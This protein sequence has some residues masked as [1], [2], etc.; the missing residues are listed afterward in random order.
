MPDVKCAESFTRQQ[1]RT[2]GWSGS[3]FR[4]GGGRTGVCRVGGGQISNPG[5]FVPDPGVWIK[6]GR[7]K[8]FGLGVW[9]G[10]ANPSFSRPRQPQTLQDSPRVRMVHSERGGD[11]QESRGGV[12]AGMATPRRAP[13]RAPLPGRPRRQQGCRKSAGHGR[14]QCGREAWVDAPPERGE[15]QG[16]ERG[17]RLEKTWLPENFGRRALPDPILASK[18][19][20]PCRQPRIRPPEGGVRA[21]QA[22]G[23]PMRGDWRSSHGPGIFFV[24]I[25]VGKVS[26]KVTVG[27]VERRCVLKEGQRFG[28]FRAS[29]ASHGK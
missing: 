10:D 7:R 4:S 19:S 25:S 20:F 6:H 8:G 24:E 26:R 12:V 28:G 2:T 16:G 21:V 18:N 14:Q 1:G 9:V 5:V 11:E 29:H 15:Q 27:K 13:L 3:R 23:V 17:D 22:L